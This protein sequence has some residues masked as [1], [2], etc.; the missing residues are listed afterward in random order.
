MQRTVNAH[1][2]ATL[3]LP[4]DLV[5][6]IAVAEGPN[7]S[8]MLTITANGWPAYAEEV[9][10]PHGGRL[11]LLSGLPAGPLTVDYF[12]TVEG[13]AEVRREEALERG[14]AA[15]ARVVRE[16]GERVAREALAEEA[17]GHRPL[18][19]R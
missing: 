5:M 17:L 6:A 11:H 2:E 9:A 7:R 12:A 16:A 8:E 15:P 10:A 1:I 4:T 3:D 19:D 14:G 18:R 13:S